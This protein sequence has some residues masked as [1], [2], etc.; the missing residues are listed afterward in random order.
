MKSL[1]VIYCIVIF[2]LLGYIGTKQT[3]FEVSLTDQADLIDSLS[4]ELDN[5]KIIH[6]GVCEVID[7]LP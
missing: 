4:V 5:L 3:S 1:H 2:L 6:E 7:N